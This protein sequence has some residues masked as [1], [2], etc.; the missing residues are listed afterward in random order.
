MEEE[1]RKYVRQMRSSCL[2]MLCWMLQFEATKIAHEKG[3]PTAAVKVSRGWVTR[4]MKRPSDTE[5]PSASSYHRTT[6]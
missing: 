4:F 6:K 2:A 5:Q 3:V 1:L